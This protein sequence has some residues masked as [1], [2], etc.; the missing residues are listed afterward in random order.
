[1]II[2]PPKQR[3]PVVQK[4]NHGSAA[5]TNI[6]LQI[7]VQEI[8]HPHKQI[9]YISYDSPGAFETAVF[10]CKCHHNIIVIVQHARINIAPIN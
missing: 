7:N 8:N 4:V 2:L 5:R 3:S 9:A 1:M 6:N 10:D